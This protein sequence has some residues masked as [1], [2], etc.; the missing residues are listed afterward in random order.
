[1][2][3]FSFCRSRTS[4]GGRM[5]KGCSKPRRLPETTLR[6]SGFSVLSGH[7]Q[8]CGPVAAAVAFLE[9]FR[10]TPLALSMWLHAQQV[11]LAPSGVARAG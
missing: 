1:M 6:P 10:D 9:L 7:T 11:L 5:P 2:L 3:L 8:C 4:V